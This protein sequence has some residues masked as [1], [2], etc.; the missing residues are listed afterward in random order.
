MNYWWVDD[1]PVSP[2]KSVEHV[3]DLIEVELTADDSR[4]WT[5]RRLDDELGRLEGL[6]IRASQ[7]RLLAVGEIKALSRPQP[8]RMFEIRAEI[9]TERVTRMAGRIV[10]RKP[11]D[12]PLRIYHGEPKELPFHALGLHLHLKEIDGNIEAQQNKE[13]DVAIECLDRG[14]STGWGLPH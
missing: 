8:R 7:G 3:L 13:I 4:Y 6:L 5:D 12:E 2:P 14:E 1:A 9:G 11:V 10:S